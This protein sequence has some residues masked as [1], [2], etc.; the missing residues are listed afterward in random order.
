LPI[1]VA[2][3]RDAVK[4]ELSFGVTFIY[5]LPRDDEH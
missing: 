1:G 4:S 2:I 3:I 5:D